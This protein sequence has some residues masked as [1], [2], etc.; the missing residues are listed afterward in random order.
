MKANKIKTRPQ[1]KWCL[2]G[3]DNIMAG[4]FWCGAGNPRS[5]NVQEAT[6]YSTPVEA[7]KAAM[8]LKSYGDFK[9]VLA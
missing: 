3:T 4:W 9:V 1:G 8:D 2:L 6:R 7:R 5:K